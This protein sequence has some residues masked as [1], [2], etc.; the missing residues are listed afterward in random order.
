MSWAGTSFW[1]RT[2]GSVSRKRPVTALMICKADAL[3]DLG[4]SHAMRLGE[5]SWR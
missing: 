1:G 4:I 5:A 2:L 3:E